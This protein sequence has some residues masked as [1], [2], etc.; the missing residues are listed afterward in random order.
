MLAGLLNLTIEQGATYN[1]SFLYQDEDGDAIN[2][3]GMTARMQ[4]RRQFA[5]DTA[6]LTLTTENGR[7]TITPLEGK[8]ELYI[9]AT[10][11]ALLT[12]SGV[13]D[14]ELVNGLVVNRLL[15]GSFNICNEVT[16]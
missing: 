1:L 16:R 8:I 4:L 11:T 2:L 15:E 10:D 7:I 14:F 3:T 6:L 9:S 12:G 5:S 13:Y